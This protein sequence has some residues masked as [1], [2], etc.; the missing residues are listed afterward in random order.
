[1]AADP[2]AVAILQPLGARHGQSVDLKPVARPQILNRDLAFA[3]S[4]PRVPTRD[5]RILDADVAGAAST[6]Q[7]VSRQQI[8]FLE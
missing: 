3:N 1:M 6:H 4:E 2:D 7:G 5:E 8:E